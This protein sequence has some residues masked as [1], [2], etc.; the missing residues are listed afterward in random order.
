MNKFMPYPY[1]EKVAQLLLSG[2]NVI[3]QAPTGA[4]KTAAALLPFLHA[5]KNSNASLFPRKCIYSV[6]MRV[7]ANQFVVEYTKLIT[8]YGWQHELNVTIQTG[9]RPEDPQLEGDLI[10]TTIDQTLSNFLCIPYALGNSRANVNAGA[11][12]ASYLVFDEFHL[13]DAQAALPTTLQMLKM[14]KGIT[15]FL[16][17]TATFSNS[18][19]TELAQELQA[20]IVPEDKTERLALQAIPSQQKERVY[21]TQ[22]RLL[23]AEDVLTHHPA[24]GRSIAICNTVD[25]TQTLFEVVKSAA[26]TGV[27]VKLLH[28]RFY[29]DDRKAKEDWLRREF[30]KDK[31]A[32][33]TQSAILIA[34]Q[35]IEVGL[36]I[37]CDVLHTELAPANAVLQR[38]GRCARY[39]GERGQVY[40]Y[41][42]PLN[43]NGD[44][45][46]L[47]YRDH[48]QKEI[49]DLTWQA[50][51]RDDRNGQVFS[52]GDEQTILS[53]VHGAADKILLQRLRDNRFAHKA[54]MEAAMGYQERGVIRELIRDVNSRNVIVRPDPN[55]DIDQKSPWHWESFSLFSGSVYG[56][57]NTLTELAEEIGHD[58][59]V[60]MRL[61]ELTEVVDEW[62][63]S[64]TSYIWKPV[65]EQSALEMTLMVAIHPRLVSYDEERGLRIGVAGDQDWQVRER[66]QKPRLDGGPYTYEQETYQEHIAGLFRAYQSPFLDSKRKLMRQ[67]LRDEL[68]YAFIKAEQRFGLPTGA[69]DRAARFIIA[70]HDLGKLG[71]EW[72]TWAH[73]WQQTVQKAVAPDRMLA[74]TDYDGSDKQYR[75]QKKLGKRPPHAAESAFGLIDAA[76]DFTHHRALYPAINTAITRHH[77]ATHKGSVK[78]FAAHPQA[79][80]AL[81]EAFTLVGLEDLSLESVQLEFGVGED[82]QEALVKP[83]KTHQFVLYLLLARVLRLAD[84]RSQ[85]S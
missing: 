21:Q 22:N 40:L 58:E 24:R 10:F 11:T 29:P 59:W 85:Q 83:E 81:Q 31:P 74:H 5:R 79:L 1:Q 17:M 26:P 13:Y 77:S 75:L 20:I 3:L 56:A 27:E 49:C 23:T 25:R 33:Q 50:F 80:A 54:M 36:D 84:Q 38:A 60:M 9:E 64:Q 51:S 48:G 41:R 4:G 78:D 35:V 47:P 68:A 82:L 28:S 34:T 16:L 7:L 8:K 69:L 62:V 39:A 43:K 55:S 73:R 30:G 72:Q 44:T 76:W 12:A 6:P 61:N 66:K 57:F 42:L 65:Y 14:L 32:Y 2:Q 53:E 45:N 19:L 18:M 52:F 67:P 15:P 37:T 71:R 63:G 70:G 46:Y